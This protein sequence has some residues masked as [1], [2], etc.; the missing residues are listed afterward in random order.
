L[1]HQNGLKNIF[2][3]NGF[4]SIEVLNDMA[5]LID[6]ANVDLKSFDEK[7]YKKELGGNLEKLKENLKLFKQLG[8][9]IE[10]TT[11]IIPT[12]NDSDEEL[13]EMATF[14]YDELGGNTLASQCFSP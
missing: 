13:E 2:V 6:G 14:I 1:A 3:T 10:I 12:I 9:W 4:E 8:I 7:Y 11:L 5:G